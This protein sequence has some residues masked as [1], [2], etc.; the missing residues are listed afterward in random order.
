MK[1]KHHIIPRHAGGTDDP[2]N[3][4]ELTVEEHADAHKLLFEK[5]GKIQDKLAYLGLLKMATSKEIINELIRQPKTEDHKRKISDSHKGKSKP[6]L[7]NNKNGAGNKGK[8]KTEEHKKAISESHKG[9]KKDWLLGNQHGSANKGKK[10]SEKHQQAIN[11]ALNSK[12]VKEKISQSW[13]NKAIVVCPHCEL[14]GKEGHNMK[15]YHFEN[16]KKK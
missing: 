3:I 13:Q 16:C 11:E 7:L 4:V 1:H 10:K 2:D 12:E 14:E 15:R 8:A 6:L 5:Y 9:M